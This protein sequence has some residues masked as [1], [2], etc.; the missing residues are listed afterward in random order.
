MLTVKRYNLREYTGQI[1]GWMFKANS[2]EEFPVNEIC[3]FQIEDAD[4]IQEALSKF[5][6]ARINK[7]C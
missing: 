1:E 2:G 6:E 7:K 4:V 3:V 5:D